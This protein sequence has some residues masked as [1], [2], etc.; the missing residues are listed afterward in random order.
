MSGRVL[1]CGVSSLALLAALS[2]GCGSGTGGASGKAGAQGNAG[3][4]GA[5]AG[6]SG[7]G[8]GAGTAG[9]NG[10]AGRGGGAGTDTS[11]ASADEPSTPADGGDAAQGLG[12]DANCGPARLD[13]L[14]P[15]LLL[16]LDRSGSMGNQEDD[17]K[18]P[19]AAP[20]CVTKWAACTNAVN[21]VVQETE[22][23][24][25]WGLKYFAN[26]AQ[27]GVE[28][29]VAVPVGPKNAMAIASSIAATMPTGDTPT[30]LAVASAGDYL[31]SLQDPN[32]KILLLAT[33]GSPNCGPGLP[34]DI[35][36]TAGAV[37]AVKA[38]ADT[39]IPVYV[40]GIGNVAMLVNNLQQLAIAGGRPKAGPVAYYPTSSSADLVDALHAIGAQSMP[41]TY[42]LPFVPPDPGNAR[43]SAA[44]VRIPR[45]LTHVEGWDYDATFKSIQLYG[46]W[47]T[48]DQ[49]GALASVDFLA[50][51]QPGI[52]P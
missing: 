33:D 48:Q 8:G 7:S 20:M 43:V 44:S 13:R 6:G 18:C 11:D 4:S 35:D 14:A 51:C 45:D 52:L 34:A 41:C 5:A 32:P 12:P 22:S 50:G 26:N 29:G 30:R 49:A 23:S 42:A 10:A 1:G 24:V 38:L 31:S 39:G 21:Q 46:T 9:T 47:C 16:L 25:R 15:D 37:A 2:A 40:I 27:C 17:T 28:A 19:I 3:A 36:D